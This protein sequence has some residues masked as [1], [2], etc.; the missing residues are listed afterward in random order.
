MCACVVWRISWRSTTASACDAHLLDGVVEVIVFIQNG[1]VVP[2]ANCH[3]RRGL[4]HP[5]D[6]DFLEHQAA[7]VLVAGVGHLHGQH[8]L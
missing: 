8:S 6:L 5:Q 7:R 3:Q 4:L 2:V 1:D